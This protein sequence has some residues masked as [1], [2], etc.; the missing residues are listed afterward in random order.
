VTCDLF[1]VLLCTL[2]DGGYYVYGNYVDQQNNLQLLLQKYQNISMLGSAQTSAIQWQVASRI[3]A[4]TEMKRQASASVTASAEI[5]TNCISIDKNGAVVVGMTVRSRSEIQLVDAS[6]N[7]AILAPS[8]T[9]SA[10]YTEAFTNVTSNPAECVVQRTGIGYRLTLQNAGMAVRAVHL[11]VVSCSRSY[12]RTAA[13]TDVQ[14]LYSPIVSLQLSATQCEQTSLSINVFL[15]DPSTYSD[16]SDPYQP[17]QGT[18][19]VPALVVTWNA[20]ASIVY[21]TVF[22]PNHDTL[23]NI[24]C[25]GQSTTLELPVRRLINVPPEMLQRPMGISVE[26]ASQSPNPPVVVEIQSL[27]VYQAPEPHGAVVRFTADGVLYDLA[28]PVAYALPSNAAW[29]NRCAIDA[30]NRLLLTY[31]QPNVASDAAMEVGVVEYQWPTSTTNATRSVR[32]M[33]QSP[34]NAL[35][36]DFSAIIGMASVNAAQYYITGGVHGRA[37]FTSPPASEL[38]LNA[39]HYT[40][41][42]LML[43]D[44]ETP[45]NSYRTNTAFGST[46]YSSV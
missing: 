32:P 25:S 24:Y 10:S 27:S 26:L 28:Q 1:V 41:G 29:L 42:F 23:P 35:L 31:S 7:I 19:P 3:N 15:F 5:R 22:V 43:R 13:F 39:P 8:V 18:A 44:T 2:V 4:L 30:S 16:G 40:T 37:S 21:G 14:S 45:A 9:A 38:G 34:P 11:N 36:S 12:V 6:S 46:V 20:V 17:E 33:L